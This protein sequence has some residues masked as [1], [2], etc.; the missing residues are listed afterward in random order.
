MQLDALTFWQRVFART[1]RRTAGSARGEARH[2]GC[3]S[4]RLVKRG[5]MCAAVA[6]GMMGEASAQVFTMPVR[7]GSP[8]ESEPGGVNGTLQPTQPIGRRDCANEEWSFIVNYSGSASATRLEYWIGVDAMAC[9]TAANRHPVSSGTP[10][11]WPISQTPSL[12]FLNP[13]IPLSYTVR[14]R[15]SYLVSPLTGN[16]SDLQTTQ[17][18]VATNFLT[19]LASPPSDNNIVATFALSYDI[20]VPQTPTDVTLSAGEGSVN[21]QWTYTGSGTTATTSSDPD[22]GVTGAVPRDLQGFWLLCDPPPFGQTTDASVGDGGSDASIGLDVETDDDGGVLSCGT[23]GFEN[24]DPND[25]AQFQRY[26]CSDLIGAASTRGAATGLTNGVPYR[27]AVVAQ[28]LAGNRSALGLPTACVRPQPLTDFWEHYRASGGVAEP[29]GCRANPGAGDGRWSLLMGALILM[30]WRRR[31]WRCKRGAALMIAALPLLAPSIAEAQTFELFGSRDTRRRWESP[32]HFLF[33]LRGGPFYPDVD[34][35]F[36]GAA[37][38][39]S[40]MFGTDDRLLL[41]AEFD[42]QILRIH[43]VGSIGLGVGAGYSAFGAIAP[44]TEARMPAPSG[45]TRPS[46]GQETTLHVVPGFIGGVVRIDALA[47]HTVIPLVPYVKF[48]LGFAYWWSTLG[49]NLSRRSGASSPNVRPADTDLGV[50]A[51]GLSLGTHLAVGL[52]LR[53]DFLERG[54]Q[55]RWDAIMGVNH[56]YLFAEYTRADVG[57]SGTQL[58]LA[59][60]TWNAGL[61]FE[62]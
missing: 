35:E 43:P 31:S 8:R 20:E 29:L 60:E 1:R 49:D 46:G 30:S 61:A 26:R 2:V 39:F 9:S 58:Q 16:C 33:E 59:T 12:T 19:L 22:S 40:D 54:A 41:S 62:F 18:N 10:R 37:T 47:R 52:M 50:A 21:V 42:W 45:W 53:L 34:G 55:Q 51:T 7:S 44:V 27:V 11:C 38:P 25:D 24:L 36:R 23:P 14:I 6:L 28:D 56:S 5:V 32:Q 57:T 13:T 17:G 3:S 4:S 15:S 48:G